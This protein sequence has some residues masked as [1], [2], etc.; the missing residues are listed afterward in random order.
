MQDIY[1]IR[2]MIIYL[3][4]IN[5]VGFLISI[6]SF[7]QFSMLLKIIYDRIKKTIYFL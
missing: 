1:T 5:L 3:I 6:S 7:Q 2:N 4:I